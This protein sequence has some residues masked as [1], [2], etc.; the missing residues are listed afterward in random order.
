MADN[1]PPVIPIGIRPPPE[2][3]PPRA[4]HSALYSLALVGMALGAL[5][6]IGAMMTFVAV[7]WPDGTGKYVVAV[8][9]GALVVFLA[10][11]AIAVFTAARETYASPHGGSDDPVA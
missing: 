2:P 11:A 4:K 3:E 6:G 10:S 7:R 1:G 8:F 5:V 9:L